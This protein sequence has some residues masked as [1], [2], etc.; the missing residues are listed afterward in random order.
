MGSAVPWRLTRVGLDERC[1]CDDAWFPLSPTVA[2]SERVLVD[3]LVAMLTP[4]RRQRLAHGAVHVDAEHPVSDLVSLLW[5]D[6]VLLGKRDLERRRNISVLK[7][8][9]VDFSCVLRVIDRIV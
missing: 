6:D 5:A 2:A 1:A 7:L 8:R 4:S 3:H 9:V